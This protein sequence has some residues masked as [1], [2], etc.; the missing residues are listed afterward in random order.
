[1]RDSCSL[2]LEFPGLND[3]IVLIILT[4]VKGYDHLKHVRTRLVY[5]LYEDG[6]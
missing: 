5:T 4:F 2:I 3:S 1:V 6:T